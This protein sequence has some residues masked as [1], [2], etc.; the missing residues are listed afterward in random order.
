[1]ISDVGLHVIYKVANAPIN[2]FPYPH[3]LVRDVFP[4]DFYREIRAHLPP[5]D[6]LKTIKSLGLVTGNGAFN[7]SRWALQLEPEKIDAIADP[8]RSFWNGVA[9]WLIGG[10]FGGLMLQKFSELL[11]QRLGDLR[12]A[13]FSDI[14]YVVQDYTRYALGPHTDAPQKVLTFLFYLPADESQSH[15]GTS[16]Y[17]PKDPR[18]ACAG[19]PHYSFDLFRRVVTMPY[20]PNTL[21]A[22]V[23]TNNS[24]HG[25]EP[26]TGADARRDLLA[27]DI[28]VLNRPEVLQG[29]PPILAAGAAPRPAS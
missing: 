3:V 16:I 12:T 4:P 10:E 22:F 18:F 23:K 8:F 19:G 1:M 14:G 25:V 20:I 5:R 24:F 7:E 26:V 21:F 13:Q 6:A 2:P 15:L 11:E 29:I 27:Y 9:N 28:K 17:V